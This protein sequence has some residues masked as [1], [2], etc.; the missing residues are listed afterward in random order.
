MKKFVVSRLLAMGSAFT[1]LLFCLPPSSV[2]QATGLPSVSPGPPA[3]ART[4]ELARRDEQVEAMQVG[5]LTGQISPD[6]KTLTQQKTHT[7][8]NY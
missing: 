3:E 8:G 4:G 5:H 6:G 1:L 2:A 7:V